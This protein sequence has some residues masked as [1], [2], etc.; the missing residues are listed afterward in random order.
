VRTATRLLVAVA[1]LAFVVWGFDAL[2]STVFG[3]PAK[4]GGP[5]DPDNVAWL[6]AL[7]PLTFVGSLEE[8]LAPP[9]PTSR[10]PCYSP[11]VWWV[12]S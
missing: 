12:F 10:G 7:A 6:R 1:S 3:G 9:R 11:P 5:G 2:L 4:F 8:A